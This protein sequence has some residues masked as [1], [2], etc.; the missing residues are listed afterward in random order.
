MSMTADAS[1]IVI[2]ILGGGGGLA[3]RGRTGRMERQVMA[4]PVVAVVDGAV[5]AGQCLPR[6]DMMRMG[7]CVVSED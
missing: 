2:P 7:R 1:W 5:A 6:R 3:M 4:A